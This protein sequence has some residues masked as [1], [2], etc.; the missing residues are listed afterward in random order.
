VLIQILEVVTQFAISVKHHLVILLEPT[1][2]TFTKALRDHRSVRA[3]DR[4]LDGGVPTIGD[5]LD[6]ANDS[7]ASLCISWQ[8]MSEMLGRDYPVSQ[9]SAVPTA[10]PRQLLIHLLVNHPDTLQKVAAGGDAFL[11]KF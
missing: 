10:A 2:A 6:Q 5:L 7:L 9:E 11:G 3:S 4:Y 1:L 8:N